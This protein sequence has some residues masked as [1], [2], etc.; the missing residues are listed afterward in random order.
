MCFGVNFGN[1]TE[2]IYFFYPKIKAFFLQNS[3]D[4][5]FL[6]VLTR[7]ELLELG[8]MMMA[9]IWRYEKNKIPIFHFLNMGVKCKC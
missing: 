1:L 5:E 7:L 3:V 4:T 6:E 8:S 2:Q 9:L